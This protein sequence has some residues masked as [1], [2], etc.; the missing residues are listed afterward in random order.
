MMTYAFIAVSR[1]DRVCSPSLW[2]VLFGVLLVV[3]LGAGAWAADAPTTAPAPSPASKPVLAPGKIV[4]WSFPELPPTLHS[5]VME[6]KAVPMASV[7][8]PTDYTPDRKFPLVVFASGAQGGSGDTVDWTRDL[9]GTEG[10]ICVALPNFKESIAPLKEDKSNY[11]NRMMIRNDEGPYIWRSYRVMLARIYAEIP[12]IDREHAAFSG[13]SN[14][15]HTAAALL[16]NPEEAKEFLGYFHR[17]VLVEGGSRLQPAADLSGTRFMLIRGGE[18]PQDLFRQTKPRLD[19]AGVP[20][21]EFVMP[22]VE[23]EFSPEGMAE[24]RKWIQANP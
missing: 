24:A 15:A 4:T 17:F 7:Y 1:Q 3:W 11:W 13:F 2:A 8:L 14:G 19:A 21:S 12:N 23:H 6:T 16:S 9:M 20:W 5:I 22:K 18:R 10:Y